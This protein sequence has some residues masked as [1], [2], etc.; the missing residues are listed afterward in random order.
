VD[1]FRQPSSTPLQDHDNDAACELGNRWVKA[2]NRRD[3]DGLIVLAD[4]DIEFH[5]TVL[6]GGRNVYHGHDGLRRWLKDVATTNFQHR[7][8]PTTIRCSAAGDVLITG[9]IMLGKDAVSPFSMR[10]RLK[11]GKV[12]EA[13]AFLSD[14]AL[15][16]SLGHLDPE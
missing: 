13:Y 7:A 12:I 15:L 1:A 14:E 11:D 9:K 3:A 6:S 16:T 5:P 2:F 4:T 8:Q 10:M